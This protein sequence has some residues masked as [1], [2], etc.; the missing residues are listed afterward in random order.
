MPSTPKSLSSGLMNTP[1]TCPHLPEPDAQ[2]THRC[3]TELRDANRELFY[4]T[5]LKYGH[6]LWSRGHAGRSILAITRALYADVSEDADILKQWPLPYAALRWIIANHNSE[7]F[8]G[9]PRISFQHQATR[10]RGDRQALRRARAWAVWAL[11]RE[12][13]PNLPG[14]ATQGIE[15]PTLGSIEAGLRAIGHSSEVATWQAAL[16]EA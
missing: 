14:D 13:K 2:M 8:P 1:S 6:S 10:L 16:A 9:N 3:L 15:E 7:H 4:H 5:A 12:A 11:I